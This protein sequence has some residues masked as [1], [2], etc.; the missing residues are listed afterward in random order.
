[1]L[2]SVLEE[3]PDNQTA[4]YNLGVLSMQTGQFELAAERFEKLLELDSTNIQG[5]YYLAV[6]YYETGNK[7]EA[8]ALFEKLK[9]TGSDPVIVQSADE[10]LKELNEQ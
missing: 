5:E 4:V 6:C 9:N 8:K 1:M 2:R 7:E 10:Y 3:Y